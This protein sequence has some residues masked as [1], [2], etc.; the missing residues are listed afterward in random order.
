MSDPSV[1][2]PGNEVAPAAI[3]GWARQFAILL[4]NGTIY[5]NYP[6]P[7]LDR[8]DDYSIPSPQRDRSAWVVMFGEPPAP[9]P[10]KT[11]PYI[12]DTAEA[13]EAKLN[14]L[15]AAAENVGV[16]NWG[17]AVVSRICS[18]FT[19]GDPGQQFVAAV[20]AWMAKQQGAD[21]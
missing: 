10:E 21:Q 9:K 20:V 14:E 4:P 3:N 16:T 12:Y 13:A 1:N 19:G 17:G 11:G 8:A 2:Q 18:P 5:G 15:R 6:P 7:Q